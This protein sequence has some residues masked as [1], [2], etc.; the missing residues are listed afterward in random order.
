MRST[1]KSTAIKSAKGDLNLPR[2]SRINLLV[3][4]VGWIVKIKISPDNVSQK[5]DLKV[6]IIHSDFTSHRLTRFLKNLSQKSC[7]SARDRKSEKF[8]AF[9]DKVDFQ[10]NEKFSLSHPPDVN[11]TFSILSAKTILKI[12]SLFHDSALFIHSK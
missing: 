1:G 10:R 8:D 3:S 9:S 4:T 6:V 7:H 2:K 5:Q 12:W 11:K